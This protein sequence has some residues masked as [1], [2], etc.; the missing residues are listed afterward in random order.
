[1]PDR[2]NKVNKL[3]KE[4]FGKILF[5][6]MEFGKGVLLTI[7]GVDTSVDL[8]YT[9]ILISVLPFEKSEEAI[10]I[11]NKNIYGLQQI[12]NKRLRMRSVPRVE[13][14]IDDSMKQVEKIDNIL[15][16]IN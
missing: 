16:K 6:E 9:K 4:E 7:T 3:I 10:E 5:Q 1:M 15:E 12:L 13:F 8:K 14:K 11:L 2:I